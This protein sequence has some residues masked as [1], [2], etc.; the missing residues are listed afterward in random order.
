MAALG[1]NM[2]NLVIITVCWSEQQINNHHDHHDYDDDDHD[3]DDD[4][5]GFFCIFLL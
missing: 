4:H 5:G 3:H 1:Q 2:I